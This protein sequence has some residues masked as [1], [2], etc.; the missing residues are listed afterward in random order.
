MAPEVISGRGYSFPVD[1]WSVG[2]VFYELMCGN[3]PFG[4]NFED[5]YDIYEQILKS[6]LKYPAF[7]KDREAKR[8][9]E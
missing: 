8:L 7:I 5:P 3:L 4:S 1:L 9:M 6:T 2:V